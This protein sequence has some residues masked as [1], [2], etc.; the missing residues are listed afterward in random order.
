M[1]EQTQHMSNYVKQLGAAA[2]EAQGQSIKAGQNLATQ[3][4][5]LIKV[6]DETQNKLENTAK[7][8]KTQTNPMKQKL[9]KWIL[10]K[11]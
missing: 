10:I 11:K 6:T 4:D 7:Q 1:D 2:S 3:A 5:I 9:L 8:L